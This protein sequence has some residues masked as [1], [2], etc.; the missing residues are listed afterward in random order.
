MLRAGR[1][2]DEAGWAPRAVSRALTAVVLV[3][4]LVIA[5]A[6]GYLLRGSSDSAGVPSSSS[7]DAGFARDMSTHHK[8]AVTMAGYERDNTTDFVLR[9]LAYDIETEQQFR[10]GEMQGW[11]NEWTCPRPAR[12]RWRGRAAIRWR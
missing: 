3:S 1:D 7:V 5:G 6:V 11:L 10:V 12:I 9:N 4:L 8:Q 2:G